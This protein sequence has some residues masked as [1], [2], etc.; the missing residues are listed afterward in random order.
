MSTMAERCEV[1]TTDDGK[2]SGATVKTGATIVKYVGTLGSTVWCAGWMFTIGFVGL[3]F[4]RGVLALLVWPY[5]LGDAV[6]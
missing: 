4:W 1:A 2:K 3:G 5:Y 6:R